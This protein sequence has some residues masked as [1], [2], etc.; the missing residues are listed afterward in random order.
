ML[1]IIFGIL[2]VALI[3]F[4]FVYTIIRT[5]NLSSRIDDKDSEGA[6]ANSVTLN[7]KV[8]LST[9]D[10]KESSGGTGCKDRNGGDVDTRTFTDADKGTKR[11]PPNP[12]A[13]YPLTFEKVQNIV[14]FTL[15]PVDLGNLSTK[16]DGEYFYVQFEELIPVGFRPSY[17]AAFIIPAYREQAEGTV[18]FIARRDGR[19]LFGDTTGPNQYGAFYWPIKKSGYFNSRP[20]FISWPAVS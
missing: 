13:T 11:D 6:R 15:P 10:C 18:L 16:L 7:S 1:Q 17:D 19:M 20:N 9:F 4:S 5:S 12:S 3:V 14:G 8:K 2:T